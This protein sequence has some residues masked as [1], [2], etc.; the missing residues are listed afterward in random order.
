M[1]TL[2]LL[3][4]I[5]ASPGST[6]GGIKTS[7]FFVLIQSVRSLVTKKNFEAFRRSIPVDR[8]TRAYVIALLSVL[9]VCIST[10]LLCILEPDLDFVQIL[11]EAVSAFGTVGLSAGVTPNLCAA[12]KF[13]IVLTMFVGRLGAFTLFSMWVDRPAPTAHYVEESISIG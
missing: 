11:F 8:I 6:G 1:F 4:F 7:T 10:L 13:V 5:G 9:V 2:I 3:M 12:S